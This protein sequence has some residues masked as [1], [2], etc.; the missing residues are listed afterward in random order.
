[1]RK[2][3]C[4]H[5]NA[6]DKPL[7]PF[8]GDAS[9]ILCPECTEHHR[10]YSEMD[11]ACIKELQPVLR[12]FV[13]RGRDRGVSNGAMLDILDFGIREAVADVLGDPPWKIREDYRYPAPPSN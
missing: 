8:Y 6:T 4:E 9:L 2:P 5:C 10:A 13:E 11:D 1:M 7:T 3:F 12:A